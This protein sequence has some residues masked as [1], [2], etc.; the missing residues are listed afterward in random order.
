MPHWSQVSQHLL[1]SLRPL[2]P[3]KR[4]KLEAL[5]RVLA[6]LA[7]RVERDAAAGG[8]ALQQSTLALLSGKP[9]DKELQALL[10]EAAGAGVTNAQLSE[11]IDGFQLDL[12]Q[13]RYRDMTQLRQYAHKRAG[14]IINFGLIALGLP[15]EEARPLGARLGEG[16]TLLAILA[17]F[18]H[19]LHEGRI[20][21]PQHELDQHGLTEV[22]LV[23]KTTTDGR[24]KLVEDF[25]QR[26]GEALACEEDVTR[27][28]P[29]DGSRAF[30]RDGLDK[31]RALHKRLGEN[32]GDL[33]RP[34]LEDHPSLIKRVAGI[35]RV[36]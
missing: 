25:H 33:F 12:S 29:D 8:S 34:V 21:F 4:D 36:R 32:G 18:P 13:R 26:I 22:D 19:D 17:S 10:E 7:T 2:P 31:V 5:K 1:P 28:L 14:M 6:L 27:L 23:A 15:V 30:A 16:V 3:A 35:F 20:H 9:T 11:L 24:R